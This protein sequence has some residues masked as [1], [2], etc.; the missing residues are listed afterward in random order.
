M[1]WT[2]VVVF[3]VGYLFWV[4]H[5]GCGFGHETKTVPQAAPKTKMPS[6]P[7]ADALSEKDGV[8]RWRALSE[9]AETAY[10]RRSDP[11]SRNLFIRCAR[12]MMADFEGIAEQL[13]S[14]AETQVVELPVFGRLAIVLDQDGD[15]TGAMAVCRQALEWGVE[16]GTKTGF[17]GRLARLGKKASAVQSSTAAPIR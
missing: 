9:L 14:E 15:L 6:D 2:A 11:D 5:R 17:T 8:R 12:A 16:D 10:R 4:G 7:L 13:R 1:I 3:T